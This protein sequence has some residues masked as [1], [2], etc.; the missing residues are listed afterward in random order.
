M[1][2]K[3]VKTQDVSPQPRQSNRPLDA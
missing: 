1:I 3:L 2:F